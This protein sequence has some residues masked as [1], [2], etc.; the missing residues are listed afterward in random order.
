MATDAIKSE[1]TR[2]VAMTVGL[3][4]GHAQGWAEPA[5]LQVT[6]ALVL[7]QASEREVDKAT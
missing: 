7:L 4:K 2:G 3:R 6:P 1:A 5:P